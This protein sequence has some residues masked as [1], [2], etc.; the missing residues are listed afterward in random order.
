MRLPVAHYRPSD[1]ADRHAQ[2]PLDSARVRDNQLRIKSSHDLICRLSDLSATISAMDLAADVA[3]QRLAGHMYSFANRP[4]A[5]EEVATTVYTLTADLGLSPEKARAVVK[6]LLSDRT[7]GGA[8]HELGV[9]RWLNYRGVR[10]EPQ[11]ELAAGE[12]LNQGGPTGLDGKFSFADV[13]FDIKS[14]GFQYHLKEQY[15]A[16]LAQQLSARVVINGSMNNALRDI[17]TVALEDRPR[18]ATTVDELKKTGLSR[19]SEL[20]WDIRVP[21]DGDP[22]TMETT[23]TNPY[24]VADENRYYPFNFAKQF[25]RNS[26]FLLVF[27]YDYLF[28]GPLHVNFAD[29]A[30]ILFR[31]MCRRA[32]I[33]FQSDKRQISSLGKGYARRID[34]RTTLGDLAR[35]LSGVLFIDISNECSRLYTN[36]NAVN[37]IT[38]HRR[39]E[40]FDF[41]LPPNMHL[42]DFVHDNY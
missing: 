23:T 9:Y 26:A 27:A 34:G 14:F 13:Y 32:F 41:D 39:E 19:I 8:Y 18:F 12:T 33:Q 21:R 1:F 31:S 36:P 22:I 30:D 38:V 5:L 3:D 2:S 7:F 17:K 6:P 24:E 40:M 15:R 35:L 42:D 28:N 20:R 10:Y 11:P 16:Q 29:H 25:T 37:P 4:Q